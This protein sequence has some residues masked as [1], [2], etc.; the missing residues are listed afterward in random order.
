MEPIEQLF[1][2]AGKHAL[3]TG[4]ARGLGLALARA[5]ARAGARVTLT[6]CDAAPLRASVAG[7]Q[8]EALNVCGR[9]LDVCA[10]DEIREAIAAIHA[11][12]G[13][14][15]V[16][17]NNA[18]IQRRAPLEALD[19]SAWHAVLDTNLSAAF[20]LARAVVPAMRTRRAGKIINITSIMSVRGRPTIGAYMASKS[21]LEAL[22]RAMAVEWG[23]WNIQVNAIGPG[24]LTTELNRPLLADPTFCAWVVDRTPAGRWGDPADL[25][26]LA[27]FLASSASDFITG[28]VIYADGGMLASL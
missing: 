13:A 6:D 14:V 20:R 8:A 10:G 24:Y 9:V 4:A 27:V 19:E 2:L 3:I 18:G 22:T 25:G 1:S 21:G 7:L 11:T 28:Q 23:P 17:I 16:L 26:G 12:T 15:D 5:V